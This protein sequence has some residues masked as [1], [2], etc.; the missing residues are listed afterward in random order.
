MERAAHLGPETRAIIEAI[1][2]TEDMAGNYL[3]GVWTMARIGKTNI[4]IIRVT[5]APGTIAMTGNAVITQLTIPFPHRWVRIHFYHM[6]AVYAASVDAL[7]IILRR[8]AGTLTPVR[9]SEDVFNGA[10]IVASRIT[11]VFGEAFEYEAGTYDLS[12]NTTNT[13]LVLPL[14]YVQKLEA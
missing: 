7:A 11:E 3:G 4:Y 5:A 6:T 10:A 8:T 9:F 1:H 12:L 14:F 13:D 2:K